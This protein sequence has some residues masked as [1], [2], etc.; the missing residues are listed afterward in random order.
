MKF[1]AANAH[2]YVP[3]GPLPTSFLDV[4]DRDPIAT[5]RT[6]VRVVS[7]IVFIFHFRAKEL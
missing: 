6:L 2:D 3:L 5:V 1:A 4:L 7:I